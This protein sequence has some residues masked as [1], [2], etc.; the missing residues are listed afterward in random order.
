VPLVARWPGKIAAESETEQLAAHWDMLPTLCEIAKA[1]VPQKLD[2]ISF[3]PTLFGKGEQEQREYLYWEFPAYGVQQA[4]RAGNWKALRRGADLASQ[5]FELYDLGSDIGEER[6]VA[7]EHTEIVERLSAYAA[8]AHT[9][10][11]VFPLFAAEKPKAKKA[12]VTQ[13]NP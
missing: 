1:D 7:A 4:V 5:E 2:G 12:A 10:S 6:N 9:P 8:A 13:A 11:N 3:A